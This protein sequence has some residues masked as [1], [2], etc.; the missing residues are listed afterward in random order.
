MIVDSDH[1]GG[2]GYWIGAP[3]NTIP[4]EYA[5][6]CAECG[7]AYLN[8]EQARAR[9]ADYAQACRWLKKRVLFLE[10]ALVAEHTPTVNVECEAC[11]QP[12]DFGPMPLPICGACVV[13]G[14]RS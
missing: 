11:G 13:R 12:V 3:R 10:R 4:A 1:C 6:R 14:V 5:H 8:V 9:A 2:C 7:R